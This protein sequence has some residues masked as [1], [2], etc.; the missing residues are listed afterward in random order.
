MLFHNMIEIT[1]ILQ[2]LFEIDNNFL[3]KVI[4]DRDSST[5]V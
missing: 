3:E 4:I 1:R 5:D 2:K